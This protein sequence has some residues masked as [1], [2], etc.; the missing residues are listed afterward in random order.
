MTQ[1]NAQVST[2]AVARLREWLCM[3]S[4]MTMA[5][6]VFLVLAVIVLIIWIKAAPYRHGEVIEYIPQSLG[7]ES[8]IN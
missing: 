5:G 4:K 7:S 8:G 1:D 2:G 6:I 3:H